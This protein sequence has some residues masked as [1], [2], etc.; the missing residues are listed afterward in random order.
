MCV[1]T[2]SARV[3][4]QSP[5]QTEEKGAEL[6][7]EKKGGPRE[8]VPCNVISATTLFVHGPNASSRSISVVLRVLTCVCVGRHFNSRETKKTIR[9]IS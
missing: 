3:L 1:Y 5:S 4:Q 7:R 9:A 8:M 2:A 6:R